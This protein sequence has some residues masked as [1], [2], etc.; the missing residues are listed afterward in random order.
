MLVVA[1][2]DD[3]EDGSRGAAPED[4]LA[5]GRGD[6]KWKNGGPDGKAYPQGFDGPID[7]LEYPGAFGCPCETNDECYDAGYCI[8]SRHGKGAC[9]RLCDVS[10]PAGYACK[11]LSV[12]GTDTAFLCVEDHI[13]LCRPCRLHADCQGALGSPD[14]R[15]V[16]FGPA[17][18]A[19][20]G[21][22]CSSDLGCPKGHTC[23]PMPDAPADSPRQCL[24]TSNTC[25]CSPRAIIEAASTACS[26]GGSCSGE[27][28]C[29][30]TGLTACSATTSATETC[31]GVD[32]D[33]NGL[34]DEGSTDTDNDGAADCV[35]A[36]DDGDGTLDTDDNCP[37]AT[38]HD[39]LDA[40]K[41]GK[42]DACDVPDPP[43]LTGTTPPS[44][45][46]MNTPSILGAASMDS[47]T[48]RLYANG[49]CTGDVLQEV[50]LTSVSLVLSVT[51][52]DDSTT[53]FSAVAL[54]SDGS[55]SPCSKVT[56]TYI[57]DSTPPKPPT[58]TGIAPASPST[59]THPTLSGATDALAT[60]ALFSGPDCANAPVATVAADATGTVTWKPEPALNTT[61]TWSATATDGAGNVSG[62]ASPLWSYTHDDVAPAPPTFTGT[63]PK[64]PS[65]ATTTPVLIGTAEAGTHVILYTDSQC[66]GPTVGEDD[67]SAAGIFSLVTV[68]QANTATTFYGK[69]RDAAGNLSACSPEGMAFIH[70]AQPPAAPTLTATDPASPAKSVT[71][72]VFGTGEPGTAVRLHASKDCTGSVIGQGVVAADGTFVVEA[73]VV[74]DAVTTFTANV[75]DTAGQVSPCSAGLAYEH[76]GTAPGAPSFLSVSPASPSSQVAIVVSGQAAPL[77][78]IRVYTTADCTGPPLATVTSGADGSFEVETNVAPNSTTTFRGVTQNALGTES[79]CSFSNVTYVHDNLAPN[80][81]QL[82]ST[83]PTAPA[84]ELEP[85][86]AGQAEPGSTVTLFE[87]GTCDG[88]ALGSGQADGS[89]AFSISVQVKA[90]ATTT[91]SATAKDEA[92][93]V[94][95]CATGL[96]YTHDG[97]APA[98]PV[99]SKTEPKSP[100]NVASPVVHGTAEAGVALK[101]YHASN[102][103]GLT[104]GQGVAAGD[105]SFAISVVVNVNATTELY[106][107][108]QDKTGQLS[109]CSAGLTYVHDGVGP[110]APTLTKTTPKSPNGALSIA[111]S[112]ATAAGALVTVYSSADCTGPATVTVTATDVGT[113]DAPLQVAPN[114]ATSF[115]ATAADA[116]GNVSACSGVSLVYTHDGQAPEPPVLTTAQPASPSTSTTPNL[117]GTSE[118]GTTVALFANAEC[119]GTPLSTGLTGAGGLFSVAVTVGQNTTTTV[120][121]TASDAAGNVSGCSTQ[122]LAFLHDSIPPATP[123]LIKTDPKSPSTSLT[124]V[125]HGTGDAGSTVSLYLKNDCTGA[126]AGSGAVQGDG[127]FAVTGG[128]TPN[129]TVTFYAS[130]ADALGLVSG[131][132]T[133]LKFVSDGT[134]PA[135]PKLTGTNPPSPSQ[136]SAPSV[137]G[138]VSE[139]AIVSI[140]LSGDCTGDA[141]GSFGWNPG[142]PFSV[143]VLM[144]KNTVNQISATL[145]DLA[146]NVSGCSTSIS[147]RHDTMAPPAPVLDST[148]PPS[149]AGTLYPIVVAY[150]DPGTVVTIYDQAGCTGKVLGTATAGLDSVVSVPV[151]V[152]ANTTTQLSATATDGAKNVSGCSEPLPF[153]HDTS[154]PTVPVWTGSQPKSPSALTTTPT[155]NGLADATNTVYVYAL[156]GCAGPPVATIAVGPTGKFSAQ[157]TVVSGSTTSFS[158]RAFD[159]AGNDSACTPEPFV[160]VHD[161]GK[162][163]APALTQTTPASPN[164]TTTQPVVHGTA[165]AGTQVS[166]FLAG[167]C[168]GGAVATA[169]VGT[170]GTFLVLVDVPPNGT[171]LLS[172]TTTDSAGNTSDCSAP[173]S[174]THDA[175]GPASVVL[176]ATSPT[177]PST[178]T[179]PTVLGQTEP[180]AAVTLFQQPGCAGTPVATGKAGADGTF[181]I[182]TP[183]GANEA[184][185]LTA[186]ATDA[187]GNVSGCSNA[188]TYVNDTEPPKPPVLTGTS[189]AS[190]TNVTAQPQVLGTAEP[191]AKVTVYLSAGCTGAA[192]AAGTVAANGQ[193]AVEVFVPAN[194]TATLSATAT[195]ALGNVSGCSNALTFTHDNLAPG[196]PLLTGTTPPSPSNVSKPVV[197]GNGTEAK[198]TVLIFGQPGCAGPPLG[199]AIANA[200]G[201]FTVTLTSD[202]TANA[203]TSLTA[204]AVDAVGNTSACS[205]ALAYVHDSI[206][207]AVPTVTGTIPPPPSKDPRPSIQGTGVVGTTIRFFRDAKCTLALTGSGAVGADGSYVIKLSGDVPKNTTTLIYANATDAAGNVS[208]CS[209]S[210]A[211]YLHDDVAPPAPKL[212]SVSPASPSNADDTPTVD[213]TVAADVVAVD[214]YAGPGCTVFIGTVTPTI[215]NTFTD[216]HLVQANTK[217]D[218]TAKAK[219]AAGNVS[220]CSAALSYIYDTLAPV[221][222]ATYAGPTVT[223]GAGNALVF[224]W[225]GATDNFT[226]KNALNYDVC[227]ST[228][229]TNPCVPWVT[230]ATVTA[231]KTTVTLPNMAANTRYYAVVRSTD[232]AGNTD[233]NLKVSSLKT[234]GINMARAV[235]VGGS[236]TCAFLANGELRCFGSNAIG[237]QTQ[238]LAH[239]MGPTHECSIKDDNKVYCRGDNGTGQLGAGNTTVTG[240]TVQVV[241]LTNM[242]DVSVGDGHSC[243]LRSDGTVACWGYNE[244][245]A[246]GTGD[247]VMLTPKSVVD[248]AGQPFKGAV[249]IVSGSEHNCALRGDA[250]AWCWGF[251]WAGQ[252]G[253][254]AE[255]VSA[256]PVA[257]DLSVAKGF[258]DIALGTDHACGVSV[259]GKVF[260]WGSNKSFQLGL[261][262]SGPQ[263]ALTPTYTGISQARSVSASGSQTCV[264]RMDGTATC[265][266]NNDKGQLGV[267]NVTSPIK[268]PT[269]VL[270][271]IGFGP[272]ANVVDVQLG[273]AH[274]CALLADGSLTCWGQNGSGQ[275]GDGSLIPSTS[276]VAFTQLAGVAYLKGISHSQKTTCALGSDGTVYCWGANASGQTTAPA[277]TGTAVTTVTG[278]PKGRA[279]LVRTGLSHTCV[280]LS[281]GEVR[282]FG[283]NDRG[284]LGSPGPSTTTPVTVALGQ[285]A[286]DLVVGADHACALLVNGAV[287]CWGEDSSGQLGN[288]PGGGLSATPVT[289]SLTE[290]AIALAAGER[291]TCATV[292]GLGTGAVKCWGHNATGQLAVGLIG[293]QHTPVTYSGLQSRPKQVTGGSDHTCVLLEDGTLNC[294]GTSALLPTGVALSGQLF[295][296]A[297]TDHACVGARD[298]SL[299]CFGKNGHGQLGNGTT[300]D[301]TVPV[302]VSGLARVWELDAGHLSTCAVGMD[303]LA[304][305]WGE[306]V[307]DLLGTGAATPVT[308]PTVVQCLP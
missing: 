109:G 285:P 262:A 41:D 258:V 137:Q 208:G 55:V 117:L 58:S 70:D 167:A 48:L 283:S 235:V 196:T 42:G 77:T 33:C 276:G 220:A 148:K 199:S 160:F 218:F 201:A 156:P 253:N 74:P 61:S 243:A 197:A 189:P 275:L 234:Q 22:V 151:T 223:P 59:E 126:V 106:A 153:T 264:A 87:N 250:T 172:A 80:A 271:S 270:T 4:V 18:G 39:Q 217:T 112:G 261:G 28:T 281:G 269:T 174:Y 49:F 89:G 170:D 12:G 98:A 67:V 103:A 57:E 219:D 233:T 23:R 30:A 111:V 177:S 123:K 278:L 205:A 182:A 187:L 105:G 292:A 206:A 212:V 88:A 13:N 289:V 34:T 225:V 32:N 95:G 37:L 252:L 64:S 102:C 90:D 130:A 147:Y 118:P 265:F 279:L 72:L 191:A 304:Y 294:V 180:N 305:C 76:N 164:A 291:H 272:L 71:P 211:T 131:C 36:D 257:V 11:A 203:T 299:R 16:P 93:N 184:T 297:G 134:V 138:T 113:F 226:A 8:P 274:G 140:Y 232:Q 215:N 244:H 286:R 173:L 91:F 277:S 303:G 38:N 210:F 3:A 301:S 254:G 142:A 10:C 14:N 298:R 81:P 300:T 154:Q 127:T 51:V 239:A 54:D 245:G 135:P 143:V 40:D 69:T 110:A 194:A 122:G 188:L 168:T 256:V 43:A 251:N 132:S 65:N 6:A 193:L 19:Y 1:C 101:L 202:V 56:V 94:S 114:S 166:L 302:A 150:S 214:V 230:S 20:C 100:S 306:S 165:E 227:I 209:T 240:I 121:G 249:R 296:D 192:A 247:K 163:S 290:P 120:Y 266:G 63:S 216:T 145:T 288:G 129:T 35:D 125:V 124:P 60:V 27:R 229:C 221:F 144:I 85:S 155:L 260:C 248:A 5:D 24:P 9:T 267:G 200:A 242:V 97:T 86:V 141:V 231:G 133:G 295:L 107:Q 293:N 171:A 255:G 78:K 204:Q 246:T 263:L 181:A 82:V 179:K 158:A 115:S 21:S 185:V 222:P 178:S 31:D 224:T 128:I 68:V 83:V 47:V 241:G 190:P 195:D 79:A 84:S 183:V 287:A 282:C 162:P 66:S 108:A 7:C 159:F 29:A 176:T 15:C 119:A 99:L 259:E 268:V 238:L 92:G 237:T 308:V 198:S 44:P 104:V 228:S 236:K 139:A 116:A 175:I 136:N 26:G 307:G 207:P 273:L 152:T 45:A 46:N 73:T 17:D 169:S 161:T 75:E 149:P 2:N 62:C 213:G 280:L 25:E 186:T 157:V 284:Q 50:K 53:T 52:A 96:T 146:G